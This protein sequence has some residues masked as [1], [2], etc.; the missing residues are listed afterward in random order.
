M[1]ELLAILISAILINNIVLMQFLGLCS[2]F[3]ISTNMKSVVGMGFAVIF[4]MTLAAAISYPIYYYVLEP[5]DIAYIE[6]IAF[7]LVI[8]SLVQLTELI[9]KRISKSLYKSLGIYL[10]L[11]ATNC[12]ILGVALKNVAEPKNYAEAMMFAIGSAIGFA[13]VIIIFTAI[14]IRL[15][16][17]TVPR[18]LKGLPIAFVTAGIMALAFM[19]LVGII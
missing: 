4:V 7:I 1:M 14:R 8:A 2:F 9:I 12:A 10:P 6:T 17:A 15:Q 11:I 18:S 19:G 5:L 16:A 13:L 3:G